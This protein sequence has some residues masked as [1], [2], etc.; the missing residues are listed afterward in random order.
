MKKILTVISFVAICLLL[1]FSKEISQI[2]TNVIV[3]FYICVLPLLAPTILLNNIFIN[4]GGIYNLLNT[5]NLKP[6][7]K[8]N[9]NKY[10]LI[11]LG[12]ISGTPSL[13]SMLNEEVGQNLTKQ[14]VQNILN[15]FTMPSLPFLI[16]LINSCNWNNIVKTFIIVIPLSIQIIAFII[17]DQHNKVS[18]Y[19][20]PKESKDNS[21][22]SKAILSTA[23]TIVLMSGSI[24]LFSL[25]AL[26]FNY[27]TESVSLL[28]KGLC[29]FSYPLSLLMST[30]SL[31][32][33][34]SV[35]TIISFGSLSLLLQVKL[36]VPSLSFGNLIKKRLL[37][38]AC[39]IL[40]TSAIIFFL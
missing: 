38:T 17:N 10:F 32:N 21:I 37:I 22:I 36:I 25:M 12:I 11:I 29:E 31:V 1:I 4:T 34:F 15:C 28:L 5:T 7:T 18:L 14:E 40:V 16:A 9:I 19:N 26:P 35:I 8:H 39:S 2:T 6:T 20:C 27:L 13:A 30:Y 3:N 33:L 24:I 23:K